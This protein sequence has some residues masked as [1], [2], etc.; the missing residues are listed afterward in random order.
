M[1][2]VCMYWNSVVTSLGPSPPPQ[3]SSLAVQITRR[4]LGENYHVMYATVYA[5]WPVQLS[6][7]TEVVY[8]RSALPCVN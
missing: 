7:T 3:L 5:C 6:L 8:F 1:R 2:L 4:R